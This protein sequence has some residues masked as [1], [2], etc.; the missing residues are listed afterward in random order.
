ME[1]PAHRPSKGSIRNEVPFSDLACGMDS[2]A[3]M[4]EQLL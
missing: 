1:A 3:F 4:M 2:A